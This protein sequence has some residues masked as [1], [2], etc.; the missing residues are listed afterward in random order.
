MNGKTVVRYASLEELYIRK[1][2]SLTNFVDSFTSFLMHENNTNKTYRDMFHIIVKDGYSGKYSHFCERIN[3]LY[4]SN[5]IVK[6]VIAQ[7]AEQIR[8]WSPNKLSFLL[9]TDKQKLSIENNQFMNLLFDVCPEVKRIEMLAKQF[10]DLFKR[11]E[12]ESLSKWIDKVQIVN[13]QTI[14]DFNKN[15][16]RDYEAVNNAVITRYSN[17][18]VEGQANRLKNI[19]RMMYGRAKIIYNFDQVLQQVYF[20]T[21]D[22]S[23]NYLKHRMF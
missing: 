2:H 4:T 22:I 17:G 20:S 8:S 9:Y 21:Q 11:K 1:G 14:N 19:K 15:H 5:S 13:S 6:T 7:K 3:N 10:K 16:L 18:Q 23:Y 12:P